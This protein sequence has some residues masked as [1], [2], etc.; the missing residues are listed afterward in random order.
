MILLWRKYTFVVN[1]SVNC[2]VSPNTQHQHGCCFGTEIALT[3]MKITINL[4]MLTTANMW[5]SSLSLLWVANRSKTVFKLWLSWPGKLS[6]KLPNIICVIHGTIQARSKHY[7]SRWLRLSAQF[8][9]RASLT[10][11]INYYINWISSIH[12]LTK[13]FPK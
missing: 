1:R 8:A 4:V 12:Y 7:L 3:K 11:I 13:L 9:E 5:K 10:R 6:F 2:T